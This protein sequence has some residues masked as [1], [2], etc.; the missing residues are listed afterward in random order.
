[1][2]A[3][4]KLPI[5]GRKPP[6]HTVVTLQE[7]GLSP[8]HGWDDEVAFN[9]QCSSQ[10]DSLVH[11]QHQPTV[12]AYNGV[13]ATKDALSAENTA[14]NTMPTLDHWHARGGMVARGVLIDYAAYAEEKGIAY[15]SMDG[16]RITVAEIEDVAEYYGVQ[17]RVGDVILIRTGFTEAIDNLT[18]EN[19][20]KMMQGTLSGVHGSEETAKW[21]WN[22]HFAAAASDSMSFETV[23]PMREDGTVGEYHE[24]G[25]SP[26]APH[27]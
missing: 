23:P 16:K 8:G 19:M 26:L 6:S 18:Q 9:T 11:W 21:F 2:N 20:M 3:M 4:A 27:V 22:K 25:M 7:L 12:K 5:P 15:H 13:T 14:G 1:M 17:F 24:L 10:W